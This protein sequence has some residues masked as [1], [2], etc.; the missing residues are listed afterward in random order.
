MSDTKD[1]RFKPGVSG[2]PEGRKP[3]SGWVGAAREELRKAWDGEHE[4]GA[5]GIRRKVIELARGGDM[6]AIRLVA[7]RVCPPLKAVEAP[8]AFEMPDGTLTDKANAVLRAMVSGEL[9]L[10][11]GAA[12]LSALGSVVKVIETDELVR[13][14]EALEQQKGKA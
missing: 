1:T 3:G 2:N 10:T 14:L 8:E 7:E 4:D 11:S 6:A 9:P 12:V 13:R 5:D